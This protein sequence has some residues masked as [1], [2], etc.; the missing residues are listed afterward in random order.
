MSEQYCRTPLAPGFDRV[1]ESP[2][3]RKLLK[4]RDYFPFVDNP[5][6]TEMQAEVR[7]R[8]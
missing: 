5:P 7:A 8:I 1:P 3:M 6:E 4:K 2:A